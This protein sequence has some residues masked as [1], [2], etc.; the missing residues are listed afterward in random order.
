M[1]GKMQSHWGVEK[2]MLLS[3]PRFVRKAYQQNIAK[4]LNL[5]LNTSFFYVSV[6]DHK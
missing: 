2:Y 4:Q 1:G 5:Y 6:L 3:W